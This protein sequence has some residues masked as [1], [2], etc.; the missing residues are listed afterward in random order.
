MCFQVRGLNGEDSAV[1]FKNIF[2]AVVFDLPLI[3]NEMFFHNLTVGSTLGL[4]LTGLLDG[5]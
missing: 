1:N 2:N 4:K 5:L 3:V